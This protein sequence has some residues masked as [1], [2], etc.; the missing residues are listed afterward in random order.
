MIEEKD[1]VEM[2]QKLRPVCVRSDSINFA[3]H[4]VE[5]RIPDAGKPWPRRLKCR[6]QFHKAFVRW[7]TEN[8]DKFAVKLRLLQRTDTL[9]HIGFCGIGPILTAWLEESEINVN[10]IWECTH[11]DQILWLDASP[12]RVPGGYVCDLCP[13][14]TRLTYPTREAIWQAE[15]FGPFLDWVNDDLG[16]AVAVSISGSVDRGGWARTRRRRSS[17]C[18]MNPSNSRLGCVPE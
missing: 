12:K 5:L 15:I 9:L 14:A 1:S 3:D 4:R 10:V 8:E 7:Y 6:R 2:R 18:R 13:E 17:Y 16:H 11:W